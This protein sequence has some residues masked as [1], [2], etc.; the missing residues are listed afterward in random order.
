MQLLQLLAALAAAAAARPSSLQPP[1]RGV[2]VWR[3]AD[4]RT[5]AGRFEEGNPAFGVLNFPLAQG[6]G[7]YCGEFDAGS[8]RS[9]SGEMLWSER[10]G[11]PGARYRGAWQYDHPHGAGVMELGLGDTYAG[12]F[13]D[14]A[15]HGNAT[16]VYAS[17]E[18]YEG[19]V[20]GGLPHGLGVHTWP[21]FAGRA[22]AT[23]AVGTAQYVGAFSRGRQRGLGTHT[24]VNGTTAVG[25]FVAGALEGR[26]LVTRITAEAGRSERTWS[27]RWNA[28]STRAQATA[29]GGDFA[30]HAAL[31][32]SAAERDALLRAAAATAV[33]AR[34]AA[35]AARAIL[36]RA[37]EAAAAGRAAAA[38]ARLEARR[39]LKT[40]PGCSEVL[41][42]CGGVSYTSVELNGV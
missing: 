39:A 7:T 10:G 20:R 12:R 30:G 27:A 42:A 17:G 25:E 2:G 24:T 11:I 38:A 40:T 13:H 32:S 16:L 35:A 8:R 5:F 1:T 4:G 31:S 28:G 37:M 18:R 29:P 15:M 3:Y 34:V 33:A 23:V 26:G 9:G 6:G 19:A 21:P 22:A 36:P 41:G 14:G